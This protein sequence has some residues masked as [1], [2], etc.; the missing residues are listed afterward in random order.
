MLD[1]SAGRLD[2][3]ALAAGEGG[4]AGALHFTVDGLNGIEVAVGGDGKT[5][6][7]DVDAEIAK[8][9]RHA[10][11]LFVMHGAAGGL[12]AVAE[13]GVEEDDLVWV[14]HCDHSRLD[15]RFVM[16][17]LYLIIKRVLIG[18]NI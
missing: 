10:K 15:V 16:S 1:G 17:H 13:G 7:E 3:L 2:V 6:L 14:T 12:L 4:D 18:F 9:M 11:L 5:S 8:L